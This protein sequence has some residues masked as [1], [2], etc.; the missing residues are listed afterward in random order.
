MGRGSAG[1]VAV[2]STPAPDVQP[3]DL[4]YLTTLDELAGATGWIYAKALVDHEGNPGVAHYRAVDM[5]SDNRIAVGQ[6][7]LT[8]HHFPAPWPG[9]GSSRRRAMRRS[10]A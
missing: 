6:S 2:L 1:E 9:P 5:V 4:V 8:R 3:G 10:A 7:N